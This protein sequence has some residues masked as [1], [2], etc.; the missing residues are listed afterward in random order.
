MRKWTII[1]IYSLSMTESRGRLIAQ[2]MLFGVHKLDLAVKQKLLLEQ[3]IEFLTRLGQIWS[4]WQ[5]QI[6]RQKPNLWL[7]ESLIPLFWARIS[8]QLNLRLRR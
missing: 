5:K 8:L 1:L 4:S 6:Q 7:A 2:R 3:P